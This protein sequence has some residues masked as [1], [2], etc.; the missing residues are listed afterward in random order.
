VIIES[1]PEEFAEQ[2]ANNIKAIAQKMCRGRCDKYGPPKP[3]T[4][5]PDDFFCEAGND[6]CL[7]LATIA[8][9]HFLG[10]DH[11]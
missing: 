2:R 10:V 1:T 6:S 3:W 5:K 11:D 8:C 9:D 4:S 7:S